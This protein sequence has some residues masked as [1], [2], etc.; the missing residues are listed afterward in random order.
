MKSTGKPALIIAG[1]ESCVYCRQMAQELSTN[2]G[3]QPLVR[4]FFVMKVD[5]ESADWPVLQQA[6]QFNEDGIPAVFVVRGD[7]KLI[8]S[9]SGKPRNMEAFLQKQLESAGTIL[10]DRRLQAVQKAARDTQ[11]AIKH[12][13]FAQAVLIV[14]E[15]SGTGSFAAAALTLA[16]LSE[17]LHSQAVVSADRAE[18]RIA[19]DK[20]PAQAAIELVHL[21][22]EFA[23]LPAAKQH[24]ESVWTKLADS[25][26]HKDLMQHAERLEQAAQLQKGKQWEEALVIYREIAQASPD[27]EAGSF[28]QDQITAVERR[29]AAKAG[30]GNAPSETA[31]SESES[32]ASDTAGAAD[33]S[34]SGDAPAGDPK[35]AASFL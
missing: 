24:I 1:N 12:R 26:E 3:L 27:S 7:G 33:D 8:Y 4:Q 15:H 11:A 14:N 22:R 5:T 21:R 17:E 19:N 30:N 34:A 9:E 23:E 6:F 32:P 28:S 29:L 13:R 25:D 18:A 10:D 2:A 20:Q 16:Q 31:Q 35:K